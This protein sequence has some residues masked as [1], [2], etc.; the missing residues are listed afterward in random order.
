MVLLVV[1]ILVIVSCGGSKTKNE[2]TKEKTAE[3]TNTTV[4]LT[5]NT[6][7]GELPSMVSDY[8]KKIADIEDEMK[9]NKDTD[10]AVKLTKELKETKAEAD[11]SIEN[12]M[13]NLGKPLTVE[14]I[15]E[16]NKEFYKISEIVVEKANFKYAVCKA[17]VLTVMEP[18]PGDAIYI[19]LYAGEE[20][21][22]NWLILRAADVKRAGHVYEFS[23]TVNPKKLIGITK[24]IVK[25]QAD[26]KAR[27]Q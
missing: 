6:L 8:N 22:S 17:K 23:T 11:N 3:D 26:Y 21:T 2:A 20:P 9:N 18:F 24:A 15:Q 25:T 12:Y 1:V 13:K 5:E 4:T 10:K 7:F 16:G 19:Q 14:I 27:K